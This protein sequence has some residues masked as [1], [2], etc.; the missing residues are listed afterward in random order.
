[1]SDINRTLTEYFSFE[2]KLQ[3]YFGVAITE[4][5]EDYRHVKWNYQDGGDVSWIDDDEF[6]IGE[7]Y[8]TSCFKGKELTMFT[9]YSDFGGKYHAIFDN[10]MFD[11]NLEE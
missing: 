6:Y 4:A 7:V 10:D 2:D 1:M 5:V 8:G 11:E 9:V 3:A